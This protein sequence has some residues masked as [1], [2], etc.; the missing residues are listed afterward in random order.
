MKSYKTL[1]SL[2][3]ECLNNNGK[4]VYIWDD[5]GIRVNGKVFYLFEYGNIGFNFKG[6]CYITF[7]NEGHRGKQNRL[8]PI[9][10]KDKFI[11]IEYNLIGGNIFNFVLI[12]ENF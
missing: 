5:E 11:T 10:I 7:R 4:K 9:G 2:K 6:N 8:N 12:R 1:E 3:Q